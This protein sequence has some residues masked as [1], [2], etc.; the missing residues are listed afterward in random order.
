MNPQRSALDRFLAAIPYAV[1]TLALLSLFFWEASI[2]K[3]PTIF[4][5]ELEWSQISRA[6]AATGHP[7]RRGE[8]IPFKTLYVFA[9]APF[10]WLH[11]TAAAYGAIK[12]FNTVLMA[13][14]AVPTF[15][16]ARTLVS[17]RVALITAIASLCTTAM[18]YAGFVMPEVMAYPVF[19]LCG[20]LS[21]RAL[22]GGGRWWFVG[23][24]AAGLIGTQIRI[25][26][27]TLLAALL[28][29]ALVLFLCG[30]RFARIR[31][32]WGVLDYAGAALLTLG[33][34]VVLSHLAGQRSVEWKTTTETFKDRFWSL[35]MNSASAF[36]I[37]LGLL[38]LVGG[39]ASL[40][41]PARLRDPQWRAFAA[42]AG[43]IYVVTWTYTAVKTAYNSTV[44]A[45]LVE[46]RN[47]IYLGPLAVVG[48]AVWITSRRWWPGTIAAWAFVTW[49]AV[50]YG[51]Q[52]DYPYFESPGYGIAALANR[53]LHWDQPAIRIA[54]GV[55]C[56]V[57]LLVA[58]VPDR[59]RAVL[60]VGAAAAVAW[61]LTAEI[62]SVRGSQASSRLYAGNLPKPLDWVE[63]AAGGRPVTFLGQ[64]ITLGQSLGVNLDEFWNRNIVHVYTLDGTGPGPGPTLTPDL[65]DRFGT[66]SHDPGFDYV[67]AANGVD[68]IGPVVDRRPGLTLTRI[69]EHPW[70]LHQATY[71]VSDDGW[72]SGGDETPVARG[73]YAYF[74]PE[75]TPGTLKVTV[76]RRGFCAPEA[77]KAH[78]VV[79]VGPLELNEQKA[80]TVSRTTARERFVLPNCGTR[81]FEVRATPPLAV[82]VTASPTVRPTEY[83]GSDQRHL[84]A[85]VG[86]SFTPR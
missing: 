59:F 64:N 73:S 79:R 12:Y 1:A 28:L 15:L 20:W 50:Y 71:G 9:I 85:Q 68:V 74:G 72:I 56:L 52:L 82:V 44:F 19:M 48:T 84:G 49:L 78:V 39:L 81:T 18:F 70:R 3:T 17:A 29:A 76:G 16:I 57:L 43:S 65:Q 13:L 61:S 8:P 75:T 2:R 51:Y 6:I 27:I 25:Q 45:T 40:W 32:D 80:P 31:R 66:L 41:L 58:T 42:F 35:G 38:P 86:F 11:S 36:A 63:Q 4:T 30:P 60:V 24:V 69:A 54:M 10:W 67:L 14:A 5:D 33:A 83:G 23:A 46:E 34:L 21:I 55:S 22:G 26:L 77:P 53:A 7:L 47:F 62:T 37:G